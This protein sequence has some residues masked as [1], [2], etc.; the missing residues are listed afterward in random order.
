MLNTP[1]FIARLKY[2]T[3]KEGGRKTAAGSGYRPHIKF[4]RSNYLTSGQ[5]IFI[6]R[7][8][9][10]PGETIDAEIII[11]ATNIFKNYLY[12]GLKFHFAEGSRIIGTGE[13]IKVL[14]KSLEK[15]EEK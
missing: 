3:S 8:H 12:P 4:E 11:I 9:V 15:I 5:Q 13:V 6:G 14:D 2:L 1:H 10:N 7:D